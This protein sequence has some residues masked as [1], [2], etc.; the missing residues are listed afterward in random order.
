[1]THHAC[2]DRDVTRKPALHTAQVSASGLA[3]AHEGMVWSSCTG[4]RMKPATPCIQT[5][6]VR[7]DTACTGVAGQVPSQP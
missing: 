3:Q 1:M 6:K 2:S 5:E 4:M 7:V